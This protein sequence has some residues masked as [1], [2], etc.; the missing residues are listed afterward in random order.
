MKGNEFFRIIHK[1]R[2]SDARLG[3]LHT[4]HGIVKTPVFMPVGTQGTVKTQMFRDLLQSEVQMVCMNG[5]HLYLRPGLEIIKKAGGIHQFVGFNRP[6]LVDS[7][8]FQVFSLADI[9]K[10]EEDGVTFMSH[11]DG[12]YHKFTPHLVAQIQNTLAPDIKMILDE[13]L[14]WPSTYEEVERSVRRTTIWAR[15]CK[16][17]NEG[18]L[19]FGIVQGGSYID[20]RKRACHE[21]LEIGF[22][23]F[24]IGGISCGEP[25][26]ISYEIVE[27]VVKELPED[28]PRYLMGIGS[29]EDIIKYV[30]LGVDMF[31]CVIPTR[32]GRTG[33][34]FTSVG[35]CVIKNA[36]YKEDFSPVDPKCDCY[37]CKNYTRAYIR[38]LFQAGEILG[39]VL[40]TLHNIHFYMNFMKQIRE[41][42]KSE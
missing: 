27:A 22:D 35:K 21:L 37:T 24:A 4:F 42:I 33:T 23:G 18:G 13:C 31:D 29:T 15:E 2:S 12:S 1:S 26:S 30:N 36:Q 41:K 10:V 17:A 39:P 16:K 5:Y 7:G 28:K 14:A 19:L 25:K 34:A 38:H 8:G 3:E 40:L 11:I 32:D 6:I 9:R 20:L